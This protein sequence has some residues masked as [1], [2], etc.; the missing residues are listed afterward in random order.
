MEKLADSIRRKFKKYYTFNELV[1][2]I[3]KDVWNTYTDMVTLDNG[4]DWPAWVVSFDNIPKPYKS[5]LNYCDAAT[6]IHWPKNSSYGRKEIEAWFKEQGF[7][8]LESNGEKG[9]RITF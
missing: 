7:E 9:W 4:H 3:E 2:Y 8:F 6:E 5:K 1:D